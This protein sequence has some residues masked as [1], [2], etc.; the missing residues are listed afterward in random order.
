MPSGGKIA[1]THAPG[2]GR[3]LHSIMRVA[4]SEPLAAWT[5][6]REGTH[7][8]YVVHSVDGCARTVLCLFLIIIS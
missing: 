2:R 1:A 8:S 7:G 3:E 6:P 5:F 4:Y